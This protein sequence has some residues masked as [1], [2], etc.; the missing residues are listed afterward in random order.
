MLA[1][2]RGCEPGPVLL[3]SIRT[4]YL[5]IGVGAV[6]G[7]HDRNMHFDDTLLPMGP[8]VMTAFVLR[9]LG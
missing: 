7:L 6:S 4:G 3:P 9:H 8:R 2:I 1:V 5:G